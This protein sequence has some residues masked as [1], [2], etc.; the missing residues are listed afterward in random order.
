MKILFIGAATSNHTVRWVNALSGLGHTVMLV[1][2]GDQRH[3]RNEIAIDVKVIY[4]KFRG[5]KGYYLN[6]PELRRI[7]N[8][9]KPDVV[10]VHYATGYATLARLAHMRPL[11]VSCWGSDIY[12]FPW[13]NLRNQRLVCRNL[14]Y[15][16]AVAS[17][18]I[19]MANKAREVLKN[20]EKEITITPF[21]VDT[22]L[23]KPLEKNK[24]NHTP[25]IGI[26]KYL[27]P[28]YD[29]ALLI[30]AFS[31]V[32]NKLEAIPKLLIYGSGSQ[33]EELIKLTEH[34]RIDNMVEFYDTIPNSQVPEVINSFDVFVN[35]SVRESFGVAVVEAMACEVPVVVTN[36]EGYREIVVDRETGIILQDREPESM[37]TA[38]IELLRNDEKRRQYGEAGRKRVLD[39]YDWKKNIC[40]MEK[41]YKKVAQI[42]KKNG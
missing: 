34:L 18:S 9:F 8:K 39:L 35:C 16:N 10:N 42:G 15:A 11:V 20:P 23:F 4:L 7:Y 36:A 17:T 13:K 33:K 14:N 27:E 32:C 5:S 6:V 29:V 25:I 2:R 37:A 31:I 3:E 19:A 21:G 26:V 40:I 38:L 24:D 28:I 30:K 41:L 22:E 12:D 1:S